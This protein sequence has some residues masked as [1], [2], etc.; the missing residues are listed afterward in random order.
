LVPK[1]SNFEVGNSFHGSVWVL[2]IQRGVIAL[3]LFPIGIRRMKE[4]IILK[5]IFFI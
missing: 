5:K 1:E 3:T 4:A 2:E